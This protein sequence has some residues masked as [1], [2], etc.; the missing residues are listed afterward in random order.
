MGATWLGD[1]CTCMHLHLHLHL[2]LH[3]RVTTETQHAWVVGR[4]VASSTSAFIG[5]TDEV[6]EQSFVW[7]SGGLNG[8]PEHFS[9][10]VALKDGVAGGQVAVEP[11]LTWEALV[12]DTSAN[13]VAITSTEGKWKQESCASSLLYVCER[14]AEAH[15]SQQETNLPEAITSGRSMVRTQ[16]FS[17]KPSEKVTDDDL[18]EDIVSQVSGT[19]TG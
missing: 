5:A 3:P 9:S 6:E 13:C 17:N 16:V 18:T 8:R 14:P 10:L 4:V 19:K 12:A 1:T 15:A 2:H 7:S 11:W